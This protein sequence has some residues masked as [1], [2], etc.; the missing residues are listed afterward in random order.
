MWL[1]LC[2]ILSYFSKSDITDSQ[3]LLLNKLHC[4]RLRG[5]KIARWSYW[6]VNISWPGLP[7]WVLLFLVIASFYKGAVPRPAGR[8][9]CCSAGLCFLS[10][11]QFITNKAG[12][13]SVQE[14]P[15]EISARLKT[16]AKIPLLCCGVC[17]LYQTW[18]NAGGSSLSH[19]INWTIW[20]CS[21][22]L[23]TELD[24]TC[25]FA[26]SFFVSSIKKSMKLYDIHKVSGFHF[27]NWSVS[28]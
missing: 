19:F 1:S 7:G 4:L 17:V 27:E 28:W 6:S 13:L 12:N 15:V 8:E 2:L 3:L 9:T 24:A 21:T 10:C 5:S 14:L 22:D 20:S 16:M 18:H 25:F 23:P 26:I 11:K